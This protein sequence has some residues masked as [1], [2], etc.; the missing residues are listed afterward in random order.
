MPSNAGESFRPRHKARRYKIRTSWSRFF[1]NLL[2]L[3]LCDLLWIWGLARFGGGSIS[4][5]VL[6]SLVDCYV[7]IGLLLAYAMSSVLVPKKLTTVWVVGLIA[8]LAMLGV[9]S[10]FSLID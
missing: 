2:I 5:L 10:L 8:P 7:A 9:F 1:V 6:L 3:A 4:E